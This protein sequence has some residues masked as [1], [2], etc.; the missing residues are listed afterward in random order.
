[1][2]RAVVISGGGAKGA[3]A[4]GILKHLSTHFPAITFDIFVG[5]STGALITPF[6][7]TGDIGVLEK[8]YTTITT[9]DVIL[10]GNILDRFLN[11]NSIYDASPLA[12]LLIKY[13]TDSLCSKLLQIQK[14][15]YIVTTCLQTS[16]TVYFTNKTPSV[17]AAG[18]MIKLTT[19][20]EV[21]RAVIA[22]A[23][24]PV[25]M[26]PVEVKK[27]SLPLRQYVDGGVRELAGVQVAIDAGA[28]EIYTILLTPENHP[29]DEKNFDRSFSILEKTIEIFTV[30]TG[31]NDLNLPLAYNRALRYIATVKSRMFAAGIPQ[32][33]IDSYFSVPGNPFSGKKPLKIYIIR[34]EAPLGGGPGGLTFNPPEMKGMLAKGESRIADFMAHLPPEGS[35]VV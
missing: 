31:A 22:S 1:M 3:F 16:N 10:K 35:T 2:K 4:V 23:C 24:E 33:S 27:G 6:A 34:P 19:P 30:E 12:K 32:S 29:A 17:Q 26:P 21:R 8:L 15:I 9:G 28:D 11:S 7:A 25:F 14:E 5:T 13:C 20:D 18:E